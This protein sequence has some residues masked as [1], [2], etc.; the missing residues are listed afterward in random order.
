MG[1]LDEMLGQVAGGHD[2]AGLA[3]K[4]GLTPEQVQSALHALT[5][6]TAEPGDTAG[7][8][9]AKTGLPIGTLQELL[10]HLG[11]EE[12]LGKLAGMLGGSGG[13]SGMA[14]GLFNR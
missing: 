9:A 6:A 13:L 2:V 1:M 12:G 14:S 5:R 11:G 7:L 4:L 3:G 10:G 8:A